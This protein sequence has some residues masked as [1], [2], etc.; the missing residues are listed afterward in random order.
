MKLLL[1]A[2]RE[3]FNRSSRRPRVRT[4]G[5]VAPSSASLSL[6]DDG[7]LEA[8]PSDYVDEEDRA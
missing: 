7:Q 2:L 5:A 1:W 6:D 3:Y 4:H 8:L